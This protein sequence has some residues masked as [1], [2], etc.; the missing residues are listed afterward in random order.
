MSDFMKA[1]RKEMPDALSEISGEV[2]L[3]PHS[4]SDLEAALSLARAT[5]GRLRV[6]GGDAREGD[7]QIVLRFMGQLHSVDETSRIAH[8]GAGMG[9]AEFEARLRPEGLSLGCRACAGNETLGRW[10]AMGAPGRRP[11]ADDPVDQVLCGAEV[12]LADGRLL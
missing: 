5:G 1:L 6:P 8:V 7:L 3:T 9:V 2:A 11:S 4:T 10:I 12:M